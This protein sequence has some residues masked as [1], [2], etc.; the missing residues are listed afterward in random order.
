MRRQ[1][2]A[3]LIL[4]VFNLGNPREAVAFDQ[5]QFYSLDGDGNPANFN[6]NYGEPTAFQLPV[7]VRLGVEV[8]F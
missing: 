5:V 4:D 2:P 8:G 7:S 1:A 6:P 3:R